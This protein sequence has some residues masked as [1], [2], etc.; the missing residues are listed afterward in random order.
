MKMIIRTT[1]LMLAVITLLIVVGCNNEEQVTKPAMDGT[2]YLLSSQPTDVLQVKQF[3]EQAKDGDQVAVVGRIGG[4]RDPW[5]EGLAIFTIVDNSLTPCNEIPEDQ[6]KT[7]WD[8][9][10]ATD[11]ATSRIAVEIVDKNEEIVLESANRLL[12]VKELQR[13]VVQGTTRRDDDGKVSL[14]ATGIF[15]EP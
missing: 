9:C 15:V 3:L 7:P 2:S 8:Y 13:V 14:I 10:C 1:G 5:V 12:K 11:I 4:E 6:C